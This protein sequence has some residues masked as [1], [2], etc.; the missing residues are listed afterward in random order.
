M[1]GIER[2]RIGQPT[3]SDPL[4]DNPVEPRASALAAQI[5]ARAHNDRAQ[6]A[7]GRLAHAR[8]NGDPYGSFARSGMHRSR[9]IDPARHAGPLIVE[10]SGAA[11]RYA[12]F[13]CGLA[14]GIGKR[15]TEP[16]TIH[17]GP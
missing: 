3:R 10:I 4:H 1:D 8:L 17:T 16:L 14:S 2:T 13:V 7:L 11:Q 12:A 15:M 5:I 9:F 6:S